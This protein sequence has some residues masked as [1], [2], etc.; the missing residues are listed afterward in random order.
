MINKIYFSFLFSAVLLLGFNAQSQTK[1]KWTAPVMVTEM[2]GGRIYV[3]YCKNST[4]SIHYHLTSKCQ[5]LKNIYT[6]FAFTY[7]DRNN[8]ERTQFVRD[9][10]LAGHIDK[11]YS[12]KAENGISKIVSPYLPET[13]V[14][15]VNDS[16]DQVDIREN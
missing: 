9:I 5:G 3:S 4:D 11:E 7:L 6:C 14:A 12:V 2:N 13:V 1:K 8:I 15:Y 10:S 16:S